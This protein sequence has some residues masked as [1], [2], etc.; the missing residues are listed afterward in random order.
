MEHAQ[1][2]D[3]FDDDIKLVMGYLAWTFSGYDL[4][5]RYL[6]TAVLAKGESAIKEL[7]NEAREYAKKLK[8]SELD[9]NE[10]EEFYRTEA[11]EM[12]IMDCNKP[13]ES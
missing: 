3:K 12:L 4:I 1:E 13:I 8:L 9:T 11:F 6:E 7:A 10:M 5:C 2:K